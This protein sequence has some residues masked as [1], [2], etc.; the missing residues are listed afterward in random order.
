MILLGLAEVQ[1]SAKEVTGNLALLR[2]QWDPKTVKEEDDCLTQVIRKCVQ[3]INQF[4][5]INKSILTLL[6]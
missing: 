5:Y 2:I 4:Y 6:Q 1:S 3:C